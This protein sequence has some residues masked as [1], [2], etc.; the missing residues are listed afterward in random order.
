[1]ETTTKLGFT[2]NDGKVIFDGLEGDFTTDNYQGEFIK[3]EDC[4]RNELLAILKSNPFY[5]TEAIQSYMNDWFNADWNSF[6]GNYDGLVRS[7]LDSNDGS[8]NT[9]NSKLYFK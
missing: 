5:A 2:V 4:G 7:V 8:V 3:L 1:M 9:G 6:D